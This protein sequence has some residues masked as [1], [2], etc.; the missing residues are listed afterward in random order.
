[1]KEF[2]VVDGRCNFD[3]EYNLCEI[4]LNNFFEFYP[5][6]VGLDIK[7]DDIKHTEIGNVIFKIEGPDIEKAYHECEKFSNLCDKDGKLYD[8][9]QC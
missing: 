1:M 7:I 9:T 5:Y 4:C 8:G 6:L 2:Y 3:E